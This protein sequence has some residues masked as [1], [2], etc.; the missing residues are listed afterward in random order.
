MIEARLADSVDGLTARLSRKAAA[1][2][3]AAVVL[4]KASGPV[5]WRDARLLWP[6][7]T[8]D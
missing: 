6:L 2:A 8:K 4:R 7:F 1:L 3:K 5:R